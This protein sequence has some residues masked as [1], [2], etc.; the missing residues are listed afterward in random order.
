MPQLILLTCKYDPDGNFVKPKCRKVVRG[1]KHAM[2]QG[3]HYHQTFAASPKDGSIRLLQAMMCDHDRDLHRNSFDITQAF[4]KAKLKPDEF[5]ILEYPKGQERF[6]ADGENE[7]FAANNM[8]DNHTNILRN[9]K[10]WHIPQQS[11]PD[12]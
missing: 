9:F 10:Q 12:R 8:V 6:N 4:P 1:H 5:I 2:K 11:T 3:I 7:I